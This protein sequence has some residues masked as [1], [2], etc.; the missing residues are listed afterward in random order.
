MFKTIFLGTTKLLPK[1]PRV[2]GPA[3][4]SSVYF[5]N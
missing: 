3:Q 1:A 2:Y 5:I 4:S